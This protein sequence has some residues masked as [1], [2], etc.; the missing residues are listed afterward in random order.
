[1]QQLAVMVQCRSGNDAVVGLADGDA[2][3][4][5]FAINVSCLHENSR[6]LAGKRLIAAREWRAGRSN[7]VGKVTRGRYIY[8]RIVANQGRLKSP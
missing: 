1:M 8:V 6:P 2:L 3:L 7:V 5:Q 4:S